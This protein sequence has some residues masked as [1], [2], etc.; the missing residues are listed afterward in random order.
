M[1]VQVECAD[2]TTD[3]VFWLAVRR[4]SNDETENLDPIFAH[5]VLIFFSLGL[6]LQFGKWLLL[7]R[8]YFDYVPARRR[9]RNLSL[10]GVA[11]GLLEDLPQLVLTVIIPAS[12]DMWRELMMAATCVSI[13]WKFAT[14]L[15]IKAGLL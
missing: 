9:K 7:R 11:I 10:V 13:V 6:M 2:L 5:L 12:W 14:P 8:D 15:L 3:F 4:Q 1:A